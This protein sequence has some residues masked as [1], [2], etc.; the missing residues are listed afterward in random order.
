[1]T[2]L[3]ILCGNAFSS[4]GHWDLCESCSHNANDVGT[5]LLS[6]IERRRCNCCRVS[7]EDINELI[8]H[9]GTVVL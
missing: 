1:M 4:K 7:T 5:S 2:G 3:C 8:K 9:L 6:W